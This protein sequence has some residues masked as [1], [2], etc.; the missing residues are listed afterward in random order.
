[1]RNIGLDM[2][3]LIIVVALVM[4]SI[5]QAHAQ[6]DSLAAVKAAV[7]AC[8]KDVRDQAK[9]PENF[10][11]GA[12]PMWKDFDAYIAPDG[13]VFNNVRLVGE[14]DGLYR[15]N[16]CL[17]EHGFELHRVSRRLQLLRGWSDDEA[18]S[19]IF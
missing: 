19:S 1:M 8:V 15:F 12:P 5:G 7:Q 14:Q 3:H 11:F 10:Q 2:R 16:K 17:A 4:A 9:R 18:S 6:S 13:R